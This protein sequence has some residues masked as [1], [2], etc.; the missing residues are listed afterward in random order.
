MRKKERATAVL[1]RLS[2]VIQDP[3]TELHYG[4]P[5]QLLVAVVLSAQCTD[6]RVNSVTPSLFEHY[7]GP[8]E[9]AEADFETLLSLIKSIS[10]PANKARNLIGLSKILIEKHRGL[11]PEDHAALLELPGVGR[12]T[13]NVVTSVLVHAPNMA[14]DTH[15][16]RVSARIGLT[17]R[18]KTPLATE[19]QLLSAIQPSMI[20][21]AHHLLILHGRY[22]CMARNPSCNT[23]TITDLCRYF[24]K[25]SKAKS[26][27][28]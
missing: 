16:H 6:K 19:K 9:M 25:T 28:I 8:A 18:A 11:V 17:T 10:Y 22:V 15:V 5:F 2:M 4:T 7:P 27:T 23:C 13:A 14:V 21:D 24:A 20:P 26:K 1:S 12:K 3:V